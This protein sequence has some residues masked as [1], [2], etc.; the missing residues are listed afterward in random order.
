MAAHASDTSTATAVFARRGGPFRPIALLPAVILMIVSAPAWGDIFKWTDEQGRINL[1][2]V[3]PPALGKAKN[4]EI[5]LKE[6]RSASIP[7]HVATPTEQALLARIE[8]LERQLQTRQYAPPVAAVPPSAP[9][10]GYYP[11][12]PPPPPPGYYGTY[13]GY[14]PGYSYPVPASY[15]VY[16]ARAYVAQPAYLG[17]RSGL[18]HGGGHHRG[19]R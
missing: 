14:Y 19:R 9:S 16:P 15:A 6:A 13:S 17:S 4:I 1:S 10:V 3:P 5:V 18:A 11:T 7:Q 8:S 12:A 2:N